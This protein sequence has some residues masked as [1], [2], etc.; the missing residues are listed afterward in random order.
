MTRAIGRTGPA[1]EV[2]GLTKVYGGRPVVGGLDLQIPAGEV[3]CLLGP[4]GAGKTTTVEILEGL[5]LRTS[6]SVTVLG[7]DP[8]RYTRRFRNRVGVVPQSTG[9]FD[10]L[11]LTELLSHFARVYSDPLPVAE[12][13]DLVGLSAKS[14][15]VCRTLSG[16]QRRRVDVA[17][18]LIGDPELI[19][20]DE[21]TTGLDPEVRRQAWDVVRTLTERGTTTV[22]TTHYLDEAEALADRIGIM[23]AGRLVEVGPPELIGGRSDAAAVVSFHRSG[24]LR[25]APLPPLPTGTQVSESESGVELR[26]V[27][28]TAVSGILI[29]WAEGLGTRELANFGVHRPSL[30]DVYLRMISD[31]LRTEAV[32]S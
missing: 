17:L 9:A 5:R 8:A 7:E 3:F 11:R 16:G 10:D 25:A 28:P 22:L 12:V 15:A 32:A 20:L 27:E 26:T 23:I 31:Q 18:A 30:E 14:T 6:G 21:P 2:T 19:F 24:A 13:I 29:G 1:I 4:N